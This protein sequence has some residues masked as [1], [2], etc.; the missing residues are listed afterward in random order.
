[1][2]YDASQQGYIIACVDG[3]EQDLKVQLS[4]K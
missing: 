4:K 1:V 2:V 3:R